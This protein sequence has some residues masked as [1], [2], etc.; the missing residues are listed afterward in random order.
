[1]TT[2][3]AERPIRIEGF[4]AVLVGAALANLLFVRGLVVLIV[5]LIKLAKE[6][7]V[8]AEKTS[9]RPEPPRSG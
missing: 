6:P 5:G 2:A 3:R 7:S 9:A 4:G 1:M 8:G